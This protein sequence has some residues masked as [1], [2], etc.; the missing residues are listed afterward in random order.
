VLQG[1][2][3]DRQ[4]RY[5]ELVAEVEALLERYSDV[6]APDVELPV[7]DDW[8]VVV[9]TQGVTDASDGMVFRFQK[10]HQ[11]RHRSAG[12]LIAAADD[13]RHI[14]RDDVTG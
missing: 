5:G 13:Y 8:V 14:T 10:H 6:T 4:E 2:V 11:W 9:A 12:L 7:V 3:I 1:G